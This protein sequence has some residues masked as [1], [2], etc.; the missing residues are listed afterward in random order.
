MKFYRIKFSMAAPLSSLLF[1]SG[2][3]MRSI[4]YWSPS[5]YSGAGSSSVSKISVSMVVLGGRWGFSETCTVI[6][7]WEWRKG[8]RGPGRIKLLFIYDFVQIIIFVSF[9][10]YILHISLIYR[11]APNFILYIFYKLSFYCIFLAPGPHI[12]KT[13]LYIYRNLAC[14]K[15]LKYGLLP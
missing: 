6:C 15:G 2:C 11:P 14:Q 9:Q 5:S 8:S 13:L 12:I 3:G 4:E 7:I 10:I 1:A